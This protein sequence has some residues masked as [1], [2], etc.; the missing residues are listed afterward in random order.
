M[1]FPF[2]S[3]G[4]EVVAVTSF[5]RDRGRA[6]GFVAVAA[7][8]VALLSAPTAFGAA[9]GDPIDTA[10]FKFKVKGAFKKQLKQNGVKMK[11]KG[12]KISKKLTS[13]VDP[14]TGKADLR[15]G[16]IVFK[17][18]K[19]KV[20][21]NNLKGTLPGKVTSSQSGK[22]FKLTKAKVTR[23]GY[24]ANL[25][26]IKVKFLKGAAKKI[27]RRLELNSLHKANVG[28]MRLSYVPETVQILS[29]TAQTTSV[30][31]S[32][33]NFINSVGTKF[34]LGH[35]VN[36]LTTG[37]QAIPPATKE[38]LGGF[39]PV[40]F[41]FPVTGGEISLDGKEGLSETT[42]G[43][44]ITKSETGGACNNGFPG[45]L[46]QEGITTNIT[47][48]NVSS[49]V[50]II[51]AP[52]GVSTG[53]RGRAVGQLID[54]TNTVVTIDPA[55]RTFTLSGS[56][57]SLA[58]SS[59]TILNLVFPCVNNCDDNAPAGNNTFAGGDLFGTSQLTVTTR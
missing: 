43:I 45:E 1:N 20:V 3:Y 41:S 51:S 28:S 7:L 42:G 22:L 4:G 21:Y 9:D 2:Q 56:V 15:L 52:P 48:R 49:E 30:P 18:G 23:Q 27:N 10:T 33:P 6:V 24:G 34:L 32:D 19:N 50:T 5:V 8:S 46:T 59:A 16:T 11:T 57:I 14:T 31:S 26:G 25:G 29:G 40:R 55:N 37:F 36:G 17:K 58:P 44:R 35:C 39:G 54:P 12:F 53:P 13:D 38:L 47:E